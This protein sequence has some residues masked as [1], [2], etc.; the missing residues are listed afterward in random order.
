MRFDFYA[1]R[2]WELSD[3]FLLDIGPPHRSR[4]VLDE[5]RTIKGGPL[6]PNLR[7]CIVTD[8]GFPHS[9]CDAI[10]F[11]LRVSP[12]S[13]TSVT[14]SV[15]EDSDAGSMRDRLL[16]LAMGCPALQSLQIE[17][18]FETVGLDLL[19]DMVPRW[20]KLHLFALHMLSIGDDNTAMRTA[21]A[22]DQLLHA[23]SELPALEW[24]SIQEPSQWSDEDRTD[25]GDAPTNHTYIFPA[26][27]HLVIG[28]CHAMTAKKL[29]STISSPALRELRLA[30]SDPAFL[31]SLLPVIQQHSSADALLELWV[32]PNGTEIPG[33]ALS[34]AAPNAIAA[35][36]LRPLM[37]LNAI[38]VLS[39][40][41]S[42]GPPYTTLLTS[43]EDWEAFAP[44]WTHL[45]HLFITDSRYEDMPAQATVRTLI[46]LAKHC[47]DLEHVSMTL[48]ET[49]VCQNRPHN[50]GQSSSNSRSD[51]SEDVNIDGDLLPIQ[52]K[53][54]RLDLQY[55]SFSDAHVKVVA[56]IL[57]RVFPKLHRITHF[58]DTNL[59][60]HQGRRW[61][62]ALWPKRVDW[63]ELLHLINQYR[64]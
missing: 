26:L 13:L 56:R 7:R 60:S 48:G 45:R 25:Q 19:A 24:L 29:L 4:A 37:R 40:T 33:R 63:D 20:P 55:S 9:Q 39:L 38:Q 30:G 1:V 49:G 59:L 2:I 46:C 61:G 18:E 11:V 12:P 50:S 16:A 51:S 15:F 57:A 34:G 32:G 41:C 5:L 6:L 23:L 44:A 42:R 3:R 28:T 54:T 47:P 17:M 31:T 14:L 10:H 36:T 58:D 53:L 64:L 22:S 8:C 52:T 35:F 21:F 27:R 62:V 43:D